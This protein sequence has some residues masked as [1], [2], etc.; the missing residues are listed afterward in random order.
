MSVFDSKQF[1]VKREDMA[2]AKWT[3][4]KD[5]ATLTNLL[6]LFRREKWRGQFVISYP[7]N[8]GVADAVFTERKFRRIIDEPE[9]LPYEK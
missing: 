5:D 2:V 1:E 7:G 3:G 8:G 9:D 4:P 6:E